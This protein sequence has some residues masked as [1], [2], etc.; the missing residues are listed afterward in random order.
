ML[1]FLICDRVRFSLL[2]EVLATVLNNFEK[3]VESSLL[4]GVFLM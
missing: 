2:I 4:S 1:S 3:Q